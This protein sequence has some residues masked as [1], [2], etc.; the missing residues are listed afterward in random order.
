MH[1]VANFYAGPSTLPLEVLEEIQK[2]LLDFNNTGMSIIE[3]SHRSKAFSKMITETEQNFREILNIPDDYAVLFMQG[4][5]SMQFPLIPMNLK[6]DGGTF[7]YINT[8]AW[9]KKAI[10]EAQIQGDTAVLAS[11]EDKNFSYIPDLTNLQI[12]ENAAYL[13]ITSNNTIAGTQYQ[14]FPDTGDVPLVADMSSDFLSKPIDV[15]KF[16]IIYAGAQKNVGPSGLGIVIIRKDL[17]EQV[18]ESVP[19]FFRYKTHVDKD[20]LFNTPNS[21]AIYVVGLVVKRL[22]KLGGL[23]AIAEINEEKAKILYDVID[24][25]SLYQGVADKN[26]RSLMN[27]TF[28]LSNSDL[29]AKLL[30]E[31]IAADL[32]GIKGHRSV[33]GFRASIYN[34]QSIENVKKLAVFLQDFENKNK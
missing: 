22:K 23:E 33:G 3:I 10:K 5:A 15:S 2:D 29:E 17:A 19:T 16:G 25:S 20:S 31:S 7:T 11:S 28:T 14:S 34:A 18:A 26:S 32:I 1:R 4:G 21:F 24:N 12:P 13:H 27:V 8:G 6:K 30:E 9:S